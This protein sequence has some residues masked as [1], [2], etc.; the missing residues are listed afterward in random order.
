MISGPNESRQLSSKLC[1]AG[2]LYLE[3]PVLGSQPGGGRMVWHCACSLFQHHLFQS[4]GAEMASSC[5]MHAPATM[6]V[7]CTCP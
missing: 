3:A 5:M 2:A 1:E 6:P 7:V 4:S